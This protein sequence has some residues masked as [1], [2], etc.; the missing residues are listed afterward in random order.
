MMVSLF[1]GWGT[2][3]CRIFHNWWD[4]FYAY[5]VEGLLLCDLFPFV[6]SI[7]FLALDRPYFLAGKG[8]IVYKVRKRS[9]R[10]ANAIDRN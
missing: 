10:D 8:R 3:I 7:I 1:L 5:C 9:H 4:V 6:C 2:N